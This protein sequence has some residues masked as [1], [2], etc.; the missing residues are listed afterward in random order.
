LVI[1]SFSGLL[2]RTSVINGSAFT[3][4]PMFSAL[5]S[6]LLLGI[7][8]TPAL[9]SEVREVP[10]I[11]RL[12]VTAP[13]PLQD[14]LIVPHLSASGVL[15]LDADSGEE[16]FSIEPDTRRPAG[17]LAKIMTALLVLERH[18]LTESVTVPPIA[19]EIGGSSIGLTVGERFT[20]GALLKALLLPSAN[21]AAYTLAVLDGRS[22]ATF[23]R[24]MN[25]RAAE[26]GLKNTHF[27]NPA[28]L[29]NDQQY[30]TPRDLA[31]LTTAALRQPAFRE[32]VGSRTARITSNDGRT[33]DLK[34][35]NELLHYN[36]EV[37]GVKTG[38]TA[39]AGECLIVLF[40][41]SGRSYLL[42]LLGSKERYTDSLHVL[43]ALNLAMQ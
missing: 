40:R 26:L 7:V 31:W 16:I 21:D 3:T 34:N 15:L 17:S 35:T 32:I 23:I 33:F 28:G 22:L 18:G 9:S 38:T 30:S 6:L 42:V 43:H 11:E 27:A 41:Q 5:A 8:P 13:S 2:I 29:D 25:E 39:Q 4:V 36:A 12:A 10:G 24:S 20:A 19:E 1:P 37:F 14:K